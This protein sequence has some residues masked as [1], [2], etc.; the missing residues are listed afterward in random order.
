MNE[1]PRSDSPPRLGVDERNRQ[2]I[3]DEKL[4]IEDIIVEQKLPH[5]NLKVN[6]PEMGE[7]NNLFSCNVSQSSGL[8]QRD[9]SFPQILDGFLPPV[10]GDMRRVP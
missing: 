2:D 5:G 6:N 3:V 9:Y 8:S 1:S 4:L 7:K 10:K